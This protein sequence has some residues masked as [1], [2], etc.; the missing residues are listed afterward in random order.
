MIDRMTSSGSSRSD[1]LLA[2][3]RDASVGTPAANAARMKKTNIKCN[4]LQGERNRLVMKREVIARLTN[5][6]LVQV[7]GGSED[8]FSRWITCR[9]H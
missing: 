7:G 8:N 5:G 2:W 6:E 1:R 9:T 4:N 3:L